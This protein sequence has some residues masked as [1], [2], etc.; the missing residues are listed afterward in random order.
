MT[1]SDSPDPKIGEVGANSAQLS[2]MGAELQSIQNS[3]PWQRGS[4]GGTFK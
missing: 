2:F 3:L 1:P 4:V